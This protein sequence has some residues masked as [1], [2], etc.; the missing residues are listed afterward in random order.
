MA[1]WIVFCPELNNARNTS[2]KQQ[3]LANCFPDHSLA[4]ATLILR[5]LRRKLTVRTGKALC[6]S[7][8]TFQ[9]SRKLQRG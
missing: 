3:I 8:E 1:A 2:C 7:V 4:P 6:N 5:F 9:I